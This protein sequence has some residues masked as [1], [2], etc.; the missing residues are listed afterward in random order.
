VPADRE[1]CSRPDSSYLIFY[2]GNNRYSLYWWMVLALASFL[3]IVPNNGKRSEVE[4]VEIK[5]A[6]ML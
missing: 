1:E 4:A 6:L 2:S 5:Q 3:L